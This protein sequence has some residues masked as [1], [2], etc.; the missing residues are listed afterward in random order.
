VSTEVA[1]DRSADDASDSVVERVLRAAITPRRERTRERLLDAAYQVFA[2]HG[3]HGA[4]IEAIC[5]AAGFTRGAFYSNFESKEELFI[6]LADRQVRSRL[7]ALEEA[8]TALDADA[9][10]RDLLDHDAVQ[11]V[12]AAVTSDPGDERH[13]YLMTT[14]FELLALR[15]PEVGVRWVAQQRALRGELAAALPRL[16]ARLG[17]R[18]RV[19][20]ETAVHLLLTA[21]EA[22][23]R[24]AFLTGTGDSPSARPSE[25]LEALVDL[26]VA[27]AG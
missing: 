10:K 2:Q 21:Y 23:V 11:S 17:L 19:D 13:W 18:F 4:S 12:L 6:V 7:A 14:E 20:A 3:V 25:T 26:L 27:D 16:L 15:D 5:D 8:V 9:P 24:E 1:R 22:G